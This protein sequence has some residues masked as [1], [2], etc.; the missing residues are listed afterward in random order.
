MLISY[1]L[2]LFQ[3]S[4]LVSSQAPINLLSDSDGLRETDD[5]S[6]LLELHTRRVPFNYMT[7]HG[8]NYEMIMQV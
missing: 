3:V 5:L 2:K 8:R 1:H 6:K 7:D 4:T